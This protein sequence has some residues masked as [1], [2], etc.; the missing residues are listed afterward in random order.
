MLAV[1]FLPTA[2]RAASSAEALQHAP[3]SLQE[4][5]AMK[6]WISVLADRS[7]DLDF[8]TIITPIFALV[9]SSTKPK[10]SFWTNGQPEG[11]A[12]R[13]Q[14]VTHA[15]VGTGAL[16]A[17]CASTV[18]AELAYREAFVVN[19]LE[20]PEAKLVYLYLPPSFS[21]GLPR[22]SMATS[23]SDIDSKVGTQVTAVMLLVLEAFRHHEPSEIKK[24]GGAR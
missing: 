4:I 15:I 21:F 23:G 3:A 18:E 22:S 2:S 1:V 7:C 19:R 8:Q 11:V 14:V 9:Q 10:M 20:K 5:Q 12:L 6:V 16:S 24:R 17:A 13:I